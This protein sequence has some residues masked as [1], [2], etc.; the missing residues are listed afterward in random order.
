MLQK[1][2]STAQS[3]SKDEQYSV[4]MTILPSSLYLPLS[5]LSL[6][7][8]LSLSLTHSSPRAILSSYFNIS[9]PL[10][11]YCP[12][13]PISFHLNLSFSIHCPIVFFNYPH[14]PGREITAKQSTYSICC[15]CCF[16]ELLFLPLPLLL[17]A[18]PH[19]VYIVHV[20]KWTVVYYTHSPVQYP[21]QSYTIPRCP[22]YYARH[23]IAPTRSLSLHFLHKLSMH[24]SNTIYISQD[25]KDQVPRTADA[26]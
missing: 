18:P 22:A 15:I 20:F 9:I 12:S 5:L 6:S 1:L 21:I 10:P 11:L 17:L 3:A 14:P 13:L 19:P 8:S 26:E 24:V 7:L 25:W 2:R 16:H 4:I 23:K